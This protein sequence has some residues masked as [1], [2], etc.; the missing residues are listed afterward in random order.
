[1]RTNTRQLLYMPGLDKRAN[2]KHDLL[3][4]CM[5][6]WPLTETAGFATDISEY[7][8]NA[9]KEGA[10]WESTIL[11]Y[12]FQQSPIEVG[13]NAGSSAN[14]FHGTNF[15]VSAWVWTDEVV[16]LGSKWVWGCWN[17]S[18]GS[19]A[20]RLRANQVWVYHDAGY[21][22]FA[23]N[24]IEAKTW[25]HVLVT[26]DGSAL[27]IYVDGVFVKQDGR[28]LGSSN[29]EPFYIGAINSGTGSN[30]DGYIQNIR[31]WKRTLD[32]A[33]AFELYTNPWVGLQPTTTV[34][35]PRYFYFPPRPLSETIGTF[36][37]RN[38]S[39]APKSGGRTIIRKPS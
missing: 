39:F 4:D 5:G 21:S 1:M 16:S 8:N 10:N 6:W 26:Y 23:V 15:S 34:I 19:I 33:D 27:K 20:M 25:H 36:K 24:A 18:D 37:M 28:T 7:G 11:G 17:N 12:A 38:L 13:L 3:R 31:T 30:F 29:T 2:F 22:M 35:S 14:N 32:R 9:T